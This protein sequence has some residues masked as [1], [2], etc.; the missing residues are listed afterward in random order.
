MINVNITFLTRLTR[1]ML[2]YMQQGGVFLHV[3]SLAGSM[4]GP[5]MNVYYATKNYVSAFSLACDIEFAPLGI[6]S[7]AFIP[8]PV[9]TQFGEVASKGSRPMFRHIKS[10]HVDDAIRHALQGL[11]KRKRFIVSLPAHQVLLW[12]VKWLPRLWVA[13]VV[14]H[15]QKQRT[16]RGA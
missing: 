3:S 10:Q 11:R 5:Y 8:G 9:H 4:S 13:H 12:L 2:K 1:R 6:R 16:Q 15:L 7:L 14:A